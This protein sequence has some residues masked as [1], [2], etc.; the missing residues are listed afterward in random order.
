MIRSIYIFLLLA[1][2]TWSTEM[3]SLFFNGNCAT[4]HHLQRASSAPTIKEIR[5]RYLQ[6]F[7]QKKDFVEYMSRWVLQPSKDTS[8][9]HDKIQKYGLMPQLAFDKDTLKIIAEYIYNGD[10]EATT[11]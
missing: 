2:T 11:R 7:P 5:S 1:P 6:A 9:M 4:C 3:G 10:I 8:L